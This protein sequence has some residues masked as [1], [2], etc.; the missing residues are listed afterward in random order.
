MAGRQ[1]AGV[2]AE[3]HQNRQAFRGGLAGGGPGGVHRPQRGEPRDGIRD[4]A[5]VRY[6]CWVVRT[7]RQQVKRRLGN[8]VAALHNNRREGEMRWNRVGFLRPVGGAIRSVGIE[9]KIDR[10]YYEMAM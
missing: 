2:G 5:Q 9:L 4:L 6:P 3:V 7:G 8:M 1:R 10:I